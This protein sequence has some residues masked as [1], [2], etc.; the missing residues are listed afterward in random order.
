MISYSQS[1]DNSLLAS[2]GLSWPAFFLLS[3]ISRPASLLYPYCLPTVSLSAVDVPPHCQNFM[4]KFHRF[5]LILIWTNSPIQWYLWYNV[6][7]IEK[8]WYFAKL[9]SQTRH[10]CPLSIYGQWPYFFGPYLV[11][12]WLIWLKFFMGAQE[13][14]IYLFNRILIFRFWFFGHNGCSHNKCSLGLHKP[15]K[16]LALWVDLLQ[17]WSLNPVFYFLRPDPPPSLINTVRSYSWTLVLPAPEQST[18]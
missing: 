3:A 4:E 13:T 2:P 8:Y 12:C 7:V 9:F 10:A 17:L 15:T 16:K 1:I 14:I 5:W 6:R 18:D 11:I